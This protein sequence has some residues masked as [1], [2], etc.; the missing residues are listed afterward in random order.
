MSLHEVGTELRSDRLAYLYIGG[1]TAFI[2]AMFG[3]LLGRKADRLAQLSETDPLT[4]L[5]NARGF[6]VRLDAEVKRA[7]RYRQPLSLL[8]LDLDGLKDIND[9]HGHKAGSE[10]LRQ[11]A[12]VIQAELRAS[13]IGARWGGDEFTIVAPNTSN[14]AAM[15]FA[16]RIRSRIAEQRMG[17]RMT[18]SIGVATLGDDGNVILDD[19]SSLMRNADAA[20]YY[21]KRSGKNTVAHALS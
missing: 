20:M 14:S 4:D 18:A 11:V 13:D 21:A 10:A 5:L 1:A 7:K 8:F 12:S 19:A 9:R 16:E 17:W 2:F 6:S 15:S 3:Y